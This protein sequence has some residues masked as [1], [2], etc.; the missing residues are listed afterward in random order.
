MLIP[1]TNENPAI[2]AQE[3]CDKHVVKLIL[4]IYL[5]LEHFIERDPKR[6][7]YHHP[8]SKWIRKSNANTFWTFI[9]F[10]ELQNEYRSRY[11][12][13]H[14]Y[15]N[16]NSYIIEGFKRH[17]LTLDIKNF[18]EPTPMPYGTPAQY[19][20]RFQQTKSHFATWRYPSSKPDWWLAE[21]RYDRKNSAL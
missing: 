3:C 20:E 21:T 12:K 19:R 11:H 6:A 5:G 18:T 13:H 14:A 7:Y 1:Y 17:G 2:C 15:E 4:E 8:Y 9:L 10:L 16:K